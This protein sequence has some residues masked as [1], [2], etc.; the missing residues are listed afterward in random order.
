VRGGGLFEVGYRQHEVLQGAWRGKAMPARGLHQRGSSRRYATL[1]MN[2]QFSI[3]MAQ[4]PH[5]IAHGGG[6]RCQH[7]GFSKYALGD[8]EHCRV[9]GGG[10]RCQHEGCVKG[11]EGG[12]T[13][14]VRHIARRMARQALPEGGLHE[15]R[16]R[17]RDA[18]LQGGMEEASAASTRTAPRRLLTAA[19]LTARRMEAASA[20]SRRA[21]PSPLDPAIRN[22]ARRTAGAGAASTW[23]APRQLRQAARNIAGLMGV[24]G[25]ASTRAAPNQSDKLPEVCT[26]RYVSSARSPTM[27]KTM[28][29]SSVA[30]PRRPKPR[31]GAC[32]NSP[33][34][35]WSVR[36]HPQQPK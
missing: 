23:A 7:E 31:V 34:G 26:A 10:R 5:C 36:D 1:V 16:C 14:T 35:G 12:A 3:L 13:S 32:E 22:I 18:E 19:H 11:A 20:A 4:T 8:T 9:H 29:L 28:H 2:L 30:R 21:A 17:W 24:T 27:H 15:V 25:A 33:G 6:R